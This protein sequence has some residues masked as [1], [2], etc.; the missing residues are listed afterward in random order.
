MIDPL[1]NFDIFSGVGAD[2]S[3]LQFLKHASKLK[4]KMHLIWQLRWP[5]QAELTKS[6]ES[7]S[8]KE[9]EHK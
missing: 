8:V 9:G 3:C 4:H 1:W 7:L 2:I 6:S 5:L